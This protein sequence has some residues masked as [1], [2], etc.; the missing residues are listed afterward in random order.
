MRK[1]ENDKEQDS[2]AENW[3]N[4]CINTML[5]YKLDLKLKIYMR[6]TLENLE[7]VEY[8]LICDTYM[9]L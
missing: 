8:W 7:F 1:D 3:L 5:W 9:V 4:Y 6:V 2:N